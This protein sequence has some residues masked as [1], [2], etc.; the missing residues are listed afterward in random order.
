MA[1]PA[2]DRAYTDAIKMLA[3]RELSEAQV[4]QR[5]ERR[6]HDATAI[7]S[8]VVRLRAERAIDDDRVADA[9]ARWQSTVKRRGRFRVVR[10]IERAGIAAETARR[11]ADRAFQAI[12]RTAE[13]EALLARRLG[14]RERATSP[15]ELARLYRY[16]VGQGWDADEVTRALRSRAPR[17]DERGE[18]P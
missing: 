11:A 18:E 1:E 14:S 4:R 9:I 5:L 13:I 2:T 3:R 12:D 8:A 15:A 16:L 6:A 10:E 17:P 7:D